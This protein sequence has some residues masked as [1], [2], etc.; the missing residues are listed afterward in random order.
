[1]KKKILAIGLLIILIILIVIGNINRRTI[2]KEN[3]DYK[4][5]TSFYPIY[6]MT[7]NITNGAKN[8]QVSNMAEKFTGCIHDYT[9]TTQDLKKFEECDLFIQNGADL[10]NF[11]PK[12]VTSYPNVQIVSSADGISDFIEDEDGESNSHIWLSIENYISEVNQI[13]TELA[14]VNTTNSAI[15]VEN[16]RNYIEK[17]NKLREL[18]NSL[19][20]NGKKAICLN[21]SLEYLLKEN[22][23]DE[24]LIET[25]HEQASIS[26]EKIKE[27]IEKMKEEDIKIIFID[28]DDDT[29]TADMLANETGAKIYVLNSGMNGTSNLNSYID[30][31][32]ENYNT[33]KLITEE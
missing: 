24:T 32:K 16:A 9:L 3:E 14:K 6:I 4:I 15:Y 2:K 11:S 10:E 30:V 18:F 23:I 5:L 12:I 26:A 1:M 27:I 20:L 29:K 17:L 22:S 19:E 25:D 8:V 7:L 31:M 33:L 21:E 13:S 28:K